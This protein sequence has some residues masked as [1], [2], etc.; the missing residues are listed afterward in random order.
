MEGLSLHQPQR[1]DHML[2][3]VDDNFRSAVSGMLNFDFF[4]PVYLYHHHHHHVQ[5]YMF[6]VVFFEFGSLPPSV[7]HI[8]HIGSSTRGAH[9]LSCGQVMGTT[10]RRP[11]WY[12]NTIH[13]CDCVCN[14][15]CVTSSNSLSHRILDARGS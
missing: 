12:L 11:L 15:L 7:C 9:N 8:C 6:D 10:R 3:L 13:I 2:T 4:Y 1:V 14:V 5:S